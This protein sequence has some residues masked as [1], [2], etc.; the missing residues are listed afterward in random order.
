MKFASSLSHVRAALLPAVII[1]G[2]LA[3]FAVAVPFHHPTI[4]GTI[5]PDGTDW[6]PADMVVDDSHDDTHPSANIKR[7][8]CTWDQDNLYIAVTYQDFGFREALFFYF[9]LDRGVG[10]NNAAELDSAA[11]NFLMPQNHRFEMVLHRDPVFGFSNDPE[12]LTPPA[13][14]FL[15]TDDAG[16]GIDISA[17]TSRAQGSNSGNKDTSRF[18]LWYNE[19]YA[20]PWDEIYPGQGGGVPANALIKM[21]AVAAIASPDSNGYDSAPDNEG[22]NNPITAPVLLANLSPSVIDANGDGQPD[23]ADATI[24]GTVTLPADSGTGSVTVQAELINFSGRD[25]G[26]PLSVTT[27]ADGIRDWALPRLPEGSYRVTTSALGYFADVATVMVAQGQAVTGIDQTL[28][29]AT[30]I[31]GTIGFASGNGGG[32]TVTLKTGSGT[33]LESQDFTSAGGPYTFFVDAGGDFIVSVTADTYLSDEILFSVTTGQDVTNIDF[34]LVRQTEVSGTVSFLEGSGQAG[35]IYFLDSAGNELDSQ[36]FPFNGGPFQFFTPVGGMFTLSANTN[37]GDV[38]GIYS[39]TEVNVD[40]TAGQDVTGI[41]VELPLAALVSAAISFEGPP[42][43]GR[44]VLTDNISGVVMYDEVINPVEGDTVS[45]YLGPSQYRFD[46][47]ALGYVPQ[48]IVF[49]V[50]EEDTF[51]GVVLLNVVRAT[52]L[53]I[54]NADGETLPEA[55]ATKYDP[56]NEPINLNRVLMAARDDNGLDDLYDLDGQ[57]QGFELS[58]RKMDDLSAPTGNPVFYGS[59]DSLDVDSVVDFSQSRAEFWMSNTAVEVLRVY[60]AQPNKDPIAGR[61]IVAFLTPAPQTVLLT[62]E[63]DTLVANDEDRIKIKAKLFDSAGKES[64]I[65]NIPVTFSVVTE[66]TGKGQFVEPTV[67][68]NGDGEAEASIEATGAGILQITAT[69][70]F[71]GDELDVAAYELDGN[72]TVITL[73]SV[74]GPTDGWDLSLPGNLSDMVTPFAVN[75][76]TIDQFGNPTADS[77]QSIGLSADPATLG[78]FAPTTAVSGQSGRATSTF[79]PVGAAGLVTIFGAGSGIAGD[80]G[81]IRLR[82]LVVIPDP[83]WYDEPANRQTLEQADLTAL[84]VANTPEDLLLEIPFQSTLDGMQIHVAIETNFDPAGATSDPFKQPVNFGHALLPDIVLT[85]KYS[86]NDYGDIRRHNPDVAS[87]WEAWSF[88]QNGWVEFLDPDPDELNGDFNLQTRWV[89]KDAEGLKINIPRAVIGTTFPDSMLLEAYLTGDTRPAG[90]LYSAFDSA[91]QDSTLNLPP[92]DPDWEDNAL[93]PVTLKAWGRT[94]V[95][96]TVFPEPPVVANTR[97]TPEE[98]DAGGTIV[99]EALVTDA[100][101]GIGDVVADLSAMGG[102]PET[103]MFDDGDSGHGDSVAGDG[104]YALLTMVPISNPGG[105]QNLVVR[106]FDGGNIIANTGTATVDVT[107]VITPI[108]QVTDPVGD[109]HGPNQPGVV[110]KFYTYP[111]NIAFVSGGFDLT[112]LT[113]F[114]T[115]AIIGGEEIDMIAFQVSV[116]DFPNPA[117]P[118]TANWS[119]LYADLNITKIDI[120][121][122]NAPGGA[123]SSL[124]WRQAAFQPWDAWDWAIICDG[125]YKALIP[126]Y[127][128]N[129]VD[130]WR[131]NALRNDNEILLLSD[132]DLDTVTALVSKDAMG[133][134]TAEDIA[135]WDIAVCMASHDF[136]G[137]EV[138]GGIRW[139]N[140]GRSEWQFAGG[141]EGDRDSN[142]MDLLLVPGVGHTAGAAQDSILDYSSPDEVAKKRLLGKTAISNTPQS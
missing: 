41:P 120:L 129:T 128:Q 17:S 133:N 5:T 47:E 110:R 67:V 127:G 65:D 75:A 21:V 97:V 44:A 53:E 7:M 136:G 66:S 63:R 105:L 9:D 10:P 49:D 123:I 8:W 134:P 80:Q 124:P 29:P 11:S 100:G 37:S 93:G 38:I 131:D 122:D 108:I 70:F 106:A 91:P 71:Q 74:A 61:I 2:L 48:S 64:K 23:P 39:P 83:V 79:T 111:T 96:R 31:G 101:N 141:Q 42:A 13:R 59:A 77:G 6:D 132:Y 82:D 43:Q 68:T 119:P 46:L 90:D 73:V 28:P 88:D 50:A 117:D 22:I 30:A 99:L 60:L 14:A 87:T 34:N 137:E 116:G 98:L 56:D 121:I 94:Y 113:V 24:S 18:P 78:T 40:V 62:T 69:V 115:V 36:G 33:V 102:S 25:P 27:T 45:S 140:E 20:L 35:T 1:I 72:E 16:G 15:V 52:H 12:N 130:S 32:G 19:E 138:L 86:A 76:Q 112:G 85:S 84:V 109:D 26:A 4:D 3:A 114:E 54:V 103:R 95:T 81:T 51:L 139:V 125:W 58:T 55:L 118:G 135:K 92:D 107:A 89:T 57:L 126:S 104:V 142:Y